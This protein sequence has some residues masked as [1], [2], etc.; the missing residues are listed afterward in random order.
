MESGDERY[1]VLFEEERTRAAQT[2]S[3][4][5]FEVAKLS[6]QLATANKEFDA[7]AYSVSHDLKAPLRAVDGF[8]RILAD[9]YLDQLGE[10][11]TRVVEIIRNSTVQMARLID[12][13]L[14]L[15]RLGRK[16][17]VPAEVDM[18]EVADD[19]FTHLNIKRP[20]SVTSFSVGKLPVAWADPTLMRYVFVNL[21]SNAIKFSAHKE[22]A[23]I[24]VDGYVQD[25]DLVYRVR[26]NG[27]GF[28]MG[29][30]HK[31]FGV[32]QRLHGAEYEGTGIGL[33]IVQRIIHRHGGKVWAEAAVDQG[34]TFYFS[35]PVGPELNEIVT[36]Q[37]LIK[38]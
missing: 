14:S 12:D 38:D 24:E 28:D 15:S 31:L 11:G 1:R 21:L 26:D 32:F 13:L 19:A 2:I 6:D 7:F 35:L 22:Q 9:E 23:V 18:T 27:V 33:A 30:Q 20:E 8:S 4:L 3:Q 5:K 17:I 25:G 16:E 36:T 10:D 37:Q 34:A 29:Y